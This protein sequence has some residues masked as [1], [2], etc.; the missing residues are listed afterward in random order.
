MFASSK[1]HYALAMKK[2]GKEE[3]E[4]NAWLVMEHVVK[5]PS[6]Q[7]MLMNDSNYRQYLIVSG[8]RGVLLWWR[9]LSRLWRGVLPRL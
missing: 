1:S 8:R 7:Q 6:Q 2:K 4:T 3:I 9:V 5:R